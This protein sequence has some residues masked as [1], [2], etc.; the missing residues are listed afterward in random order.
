ML[1]N[2]DSP[3]RETGRRGSLRQTCPSVLA[4]MPSKKGK[5]EQKT[6]LNENAFENSFVRL[7]Y[8]LRG[9]IQALS[10]REIVAAFGDL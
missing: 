9:G 10:S 4:F 2:A 3:P 7:S 8:R 5:A 6:H 1:G